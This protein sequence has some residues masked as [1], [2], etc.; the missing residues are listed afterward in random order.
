MVD[1][2]VT[3][4]SICSGIEAATVAWEPLGFRAAWLAEINPFCS[5]LLA[6]R[7][8]DVENRGDFTRIDRG[9]GAI[10]ILAGGT[11]CQSFVSFQ[12]ACMKPA[13]HNC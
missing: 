11:P 8:P 1:A 13:G 9:P 10:D 2:P 4:A 6:H 3:F 5:A 7:F 12:Q